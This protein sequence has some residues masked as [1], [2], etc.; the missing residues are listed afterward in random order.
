MPRPPPDLPVIFPTNRIFKEDCDYPLPKAFEKPVNAVHISYALINLVNKSERGIKQKR[1]PNQNFNYCIEK[2]N[3]QSTSNNYEQQVNDEKDKTFSINSSDSYERELP[4]GKIISNSQRKIDSFLVYK[5]LS[6]DRTKE[7][8]LEN[9]LNGGKHNQSKNRLR[10]GD[11]NDLYE[12]D[13][14]ED[15]TLEKQAL[16]LESTMMQLKGETKEKELE[17]VLTESKHQF[18]TEDKNELYDKNLSQALTLEDHAFD[19]ESTFLRLKETKSLLNQ[20]K[21][22]SITQNN[23]K[24]NSKYAV[25]NTFTEE[26]VGDELLSK[27]SSLKYAMENIRLRAGMDD[28]WQDG[29]CGDIPCFLQN[30]NPTCDPDCPLNNNP[31]PTGCGFCPSERPRIK[32]SPQPSM[33]I[34]NKKYDFD[35]FY[36]KPIPRYSFKCTA[37]CG[38]P[39]EIP[40]CEECFKNEPP[41]N[42]YSCDKR[43]AKHCYLS[44]VAPYPEPMV[45][46]IICFFFVKT[47]FEKSKK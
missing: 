13:S 34:L 6:L 29:K 39:P 47:R 16:I 9:I 28:K 11:N 17:G 7:K 22:K 18:R 31:V 14:L 25:T 5:P 41:E 44:S 43:N 32:V 20:I 10:A 2:Q 33:N 19:L 35:P 37:E 15:L 21:T 45:S 8:E 1:P 36:I 40:C 12:K 38:R 46:G 42:D 3:Q 27:Y 30:Q 26:N 23:A 4:T 24:N